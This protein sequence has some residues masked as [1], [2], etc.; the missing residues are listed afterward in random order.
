M[1]REE[2]NFAVFCVE[3]VAEALKIS[4]DKCYEMLTEES[5][6]L[7]DYIVPCYEPLHTQGKEYIVQEII[8]VMRRKGV[9]E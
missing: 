5:T 4:S 9:I 3:W 1:N 8:D 2:L 6:L 7:Y